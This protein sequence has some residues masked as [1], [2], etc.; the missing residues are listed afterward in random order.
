[1]RRLLEL[2][3]TL[4]TEPAAYWRTPAQRAAGCLIRTTPP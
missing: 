2:D 3:A 1:V 4:E